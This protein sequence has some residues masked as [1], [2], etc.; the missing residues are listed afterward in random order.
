MDDVQVARRWRSASM[1]DVGLVRAV[2]EDACLELVDRG[3]WLVADGMGGHAAGDFASAA[4]V[5]GLFEL[6]PARYLADMISN[7]SDRIRET[8]R[9]LFEESAR[10]GL[11]VIGATVAVLILF[12]RH[13]V[14][15]WAGD[16]RIY[17][18]RNGHLAHLTRDHRRVEE[19]VSRGLMTR[20]MA[21]RHPMS[22]EITRAVGADAALELS[23][24][25]RDLLPTDRFLICS[26]GLH[27]EVSDDEIE[28]ILSSGSPSD[29]CRALVSA[30]KEAGA[31]D[32]VTVVVV[33]AETL[34]GP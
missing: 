30:A 4:V 13:S 34:G 32:N 33:Q 12:G 6:K 17:R 3:V 14:C 9:Y 11:G 15:I 28:R 20:Q 7:I 10:R 22:H 26:D 31:H 27:G 1:S 24:E 23:V 18:L 8:N 25:M 16:S 29:N 5:K 2:N 19:Y 21:E